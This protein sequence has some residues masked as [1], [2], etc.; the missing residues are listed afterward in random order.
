MYNL[1]QPLR[2][3]RLF[4]IRLEERNLVRFPVGV[5]VGLN[6]DRGQLEGV[7]PENGVHVI[8]QR[9]LV[10]RIQFGVLLEQLFVNPFAE[11]AGF[12]M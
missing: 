11:P 3:T 4:Q 8:A 7:L 12:N 1:G 2:P 6:R 9:L 5:F 10:G